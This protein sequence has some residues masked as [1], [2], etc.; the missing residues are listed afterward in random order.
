MASIGRLTWVPFIN[1]RTRFGVP[2]FCGSRMIR[3]LLDGA[4]AGGWEEEICLSRFC[5]QRQT[6]MITKVTKR[7]A[8]IIIPVFCPAFKTGVE[9]GGVAVGVDIAKQVSELEAFEQPLWQPW[10][11][12]QYSSVL[13]QYLVNQHQL[14]SWDLGTGKRR[15]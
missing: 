12:R 13:P 1:W 8:P 3:V 10:H 7:K 6:S 9:D 2:G 14:S 4:E 5:F 15:F 11:R